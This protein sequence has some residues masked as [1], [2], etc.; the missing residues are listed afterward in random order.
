[1]SETN[2]PKGLIRESYRME[3]IDASQCR[4]IFLDWA[5]SVP[6]GVDP[7]TWIT[8]LLEEYDDQPKDHPMTVVLQDALTPPEQTGRRG[9]ARARR[10]SG[11]CRD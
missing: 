4:S 8:A 11:E 10:Q 2:D 9:G 1:M 7:T 3:G 6:M 5:I